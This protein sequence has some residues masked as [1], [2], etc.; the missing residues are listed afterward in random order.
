MLENEIRLQLQF[1]SRYLKVRGEGLTL[2]RLKEKC[3][4]PFSCL[5]MDTDKLA[6]TTHALQ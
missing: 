4:M 1:T 5:G 3:V 2:D 6:T